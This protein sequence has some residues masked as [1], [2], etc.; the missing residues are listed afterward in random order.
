MRTRSFREPSGA[1]CRSLG[2]PGF[3]VELGGVGGLH[4]PFLTERRTR[5]RVRRSVAGN[6]GSLGMTKERGALPL[7]EALGMAECVV[8]LPSEGSSIRITN[9]NGSAPLSFVIPSEA[10]GSAVRPG[11]LPKAS[12]SHTRSIA[13][14]F[15]RFTARLKSCPDTKQKPKIKEIFL[16]VDSKNVETPGPGLLVRGSG[17]SNPRERTAI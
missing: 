5:D 17:L 11:W 16:R 14:M 6:P 9:P 15:S 3:P 2:F 12:G 13:L 10:E 4:A 8:L 7:T 1:H